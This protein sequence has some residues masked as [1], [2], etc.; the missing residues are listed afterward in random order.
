MYCVKGTW[1]S[2]FESDLLRCVLECFFVEVSRIA[3]DGF[4]WRWN[5]FGEFYDGKSL[6]EGAV[7]NKP[8]EKMFFQY[9]IAE[10]CCKKIFCFVDDC[11]FYV[12]SFLKNVQ[13]FVCSGKSR[14]FAPQKQFI[15]NN[16]L[17][18]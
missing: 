10:I 14:T 15:I 5:V 11:F 9:P 6:F 13:R 18:N 17:T 3:F 12:L 1:L 7:R 8:D 2:C 16:K 4:V